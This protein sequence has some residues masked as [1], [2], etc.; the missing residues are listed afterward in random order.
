MKDFKFV[1]VLTLLV[2]LSVWFG[3]K[4]FF[5]SISDNV[6]RFHVLANSNTVEDQLIKEHVRDAVLDF[7]NPLLID[8][9]SIEDSRIIINENIDDIQSIAEQVTKNYDKDYIVEVE[10]AKVDFPSRVY[11]TETYPA[12]EY[13]AC[14]IL[15]GE[16]V[17]ENWWCVMYPPLCYVD[18]ATSIDYSENIIDKPF[19]IRFKLV[20]WL[21]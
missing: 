13:E 3:T 10:I 4:S 16:A 2:A 14:R 5:H 11:G 21:F 8:V 7:I 1:S 15:I 6:I 18:V 9:Q 20:E 17:G 19:N 12:G